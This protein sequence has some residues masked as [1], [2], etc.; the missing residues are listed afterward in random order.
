M[1]WHKLITMLDFSV[2]D[3]RRQKMAEKTPCIGTVIV[4]IYNF[5]LYLIVSV[6]MHQCLMHVY[7][8]AISFACF[9]LSHFSVS[10]CVLCS[11]F[12]ASA[13]SA[14]T[15]LVG[16]QEGHPACKKTE[17]WG[18]GV[19]ICLE[20]CADLHTAQLIPLPLAVTCCSKIQ[21]GFTFLVPAYVGSPKKGR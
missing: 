14:L 21:I 2:A 13:F 6:T 20:R 5:S 11:A 3:C 1:L 18:A 17:W 9:L 7:V 4:R 15:L 19:V 16:R 10:M 8:Y 12:S